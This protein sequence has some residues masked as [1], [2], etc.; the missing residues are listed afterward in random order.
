MATVT[1]ASRSHTAITEA[2]VPVGVAAHE[3]GHAAQ[4]RVG[5]S[6]QLEGVGVAGAD[7]VQE[8]GLRRGPEEPV[9][10]VAGLATTVDGTSRT[11]SFPRNHAVHSA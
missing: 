3:L 8:G 9:D 1:I 6:G 5:Q 7:A 11:S 2:S 10:Q 4:V